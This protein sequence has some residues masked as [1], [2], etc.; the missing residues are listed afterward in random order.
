[1]KLDQ[2]E[3]IRVSGCPAGNETRS[4]IISQ[5][6]PNFPQTVGKKKE[7]FTFYFGP[8]EILRGT[9]FISTIP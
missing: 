4:Q 7:R 6:P 8:L 3:N 1:M 5:D 9:D 2:K